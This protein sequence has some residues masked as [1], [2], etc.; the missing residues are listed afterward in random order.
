MRRELAR[1]IATCGY[2]GYLPVA[3]GTWGTLLAF[4]V[5]LLLPRSQ[6]SLIIA[7]AVSFALG[8]WAAR[9]GARELWPDSRK[10][11]DPGRICVDEFAAFFVAVMFLPY[12][13]VYGLFAFFL[14]RVFDIVKPF[15]G[16]RCEKIPGGWGIM[17]DDFVAGIYANVC[18][19]ILRLTASLVSFPYAE[20]F[21]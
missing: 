6:W 10:K 2:V 5:Y 9:V 15:P 1:F 11:N 4:G 12:G 20:H 7:F 21:K 3:P 16:R 8:A 17:A 18:L 13:I 19:Q 14:T